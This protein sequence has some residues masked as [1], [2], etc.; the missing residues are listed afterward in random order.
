MKEVKKQL[1]G[2]PV[3]A[4][5]NDGET[6]WIE[7]KSPDGD[8]MLAIDKDGSVVLELFEPISLVRHGKVI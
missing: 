2:F 5:V 4:F 3:S 7:V 1:G 8:F 6:V